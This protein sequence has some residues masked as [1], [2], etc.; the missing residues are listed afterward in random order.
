MNIDFDALMPTQKKNLIEAITINIQVL[1]FVVYLI[2]SKSLLSSTLGFMDPETRGPL[3]GEFA[4]F[5][6]LTPRCWL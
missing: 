2:L 1:D 4:F 5:G 3:R 6:P